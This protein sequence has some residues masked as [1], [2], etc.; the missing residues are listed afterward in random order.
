MDGQ[1]LDAKGPPCIGLGLLRFSYL[2]ALLRLL[3]SFLVLTEVVIEERTPTTIA[4]MVALGA[5]PVVFARV[6][7]DFIVHLK[8]GAVKP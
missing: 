6:R 4:F 1:P 2:I 8:N 3:L 5:F 7:Y